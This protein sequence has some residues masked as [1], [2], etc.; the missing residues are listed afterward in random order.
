MIVRILGEGQYSVPDK[1]RSEMDAL[2]NS[3]L[4]AVD[5]GDEAAFKV[6]LGAA[7]AEVR[8]VGT[9]LPDDEFAP[10]DLVLPFEDATLSETKELLAGGAAADG[11][12]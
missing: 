8:R 5:A 7:V 11:D 10:S 6:A 9:V 4:E 12:L 1:H 2:D 3:L